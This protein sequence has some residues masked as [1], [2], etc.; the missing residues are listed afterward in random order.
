M[1]ISV[2]AQ[3]VQFIYSLA[4]GA[5]LGLL[6]DMFRIIRIAFMPGKV[7]LI[8][9]DIIYMIISAISTFAFIFNI[10]SG[11]LRLFIFIG[12]ILGFIVYYFTLGTLV[13]KSA[14]VII[15]ILK[16]I[17][18]FIFRVVSLPFVKIYVIFLP[19]FEFLLKKVKIFMLFLKKHFLFMKKRYIIYMNNKIVLLSF[20]FKKKEKHKN[21][22][23]VAAVKSAR[24]RH[25]N[26][27]NYNGVSGVCKKQRTK[28][29]K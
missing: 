8:Y 5:A 19:V 17:L 11:S 20:K 16:K 7:I 26:N 21:E 3:L 18:T 14:K 28:K 2:S 10:N 27:V 12:V 15:D 1:G 4:F 29:R 13:F 9:E 23:S 25:R 24:L 22:S 6:Y